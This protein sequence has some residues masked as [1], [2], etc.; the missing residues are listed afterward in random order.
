MAQETLALWAERV[1][2][3]NHPLTVDDL[4]ALP[5][6]GRLYEL[7]EGRLVLIPP[8]GGGNASRAARLLVALG[9]FVEARG[10]GLVTG[11]DG[12]YMLRQTGRTGYGSGARCGF[13]A[14]WSLPLPRFACV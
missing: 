8:T 9:A 10:L 6:D 4:L 2:K 12:A 13:C 5:D 3:T 11:A 1:I 7:V 14:H